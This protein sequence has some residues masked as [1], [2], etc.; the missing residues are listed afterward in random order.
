MRCHPQWSDK[1]K[2]I[3]NTAMIR[4]RREKK[5]GLSRDFE[6]SR[7]DQ[8]FDPRILDEFDRSKLDVRIEGRRTT[9]GPIMCFSGRLTGLSAGVQH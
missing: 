8:V 7:F 3:E 5:R 1:S 9:R 2:M 4:E 6:Y